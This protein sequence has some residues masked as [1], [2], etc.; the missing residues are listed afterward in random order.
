MNLNVNGQFPQ[1]LGEEEKGHTPIP[2]P[3]SVIGELSRLMNIRITSG[4]EKNPLL[5]KSARLIMMELAR[6][7]GITQLDLVKA[8]HLK[9]PTISVTLQKLEKDGYVERRPDNYD[10]RAIR[11]FLTEKGSAYNSYIIKK[12]KDVEDYALSCLTDTETKQLMR[13]L[14]KLKDNLIEESE[15][16]K[17]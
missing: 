16:N 17:Y 4:A 8:T 13:I 14:L 5:Q 7:D 2:N 10:L 15:K 11:V 1:G 6:K 12:V 9:A 3:M